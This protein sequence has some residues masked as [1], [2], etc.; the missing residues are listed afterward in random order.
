M[1]AKMMIVGDEQTKGEREH[2]VANR[3]LAQS[4]MCSWKQMKK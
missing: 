1:E 2:D 4:R 3:H